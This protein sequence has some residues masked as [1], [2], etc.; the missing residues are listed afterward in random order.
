V[1][2]KQN[3]FLLVSIYK[4]IRMETYGFF[5]FGIDNKDFYPNEHSIIQEL[6]VTNFP[7]AFIYF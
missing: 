4:K 2:G 6:R 5:Y 1:F 7:F 3:N